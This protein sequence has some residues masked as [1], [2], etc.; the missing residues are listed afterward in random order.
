MNLLLFIGLLVVA[1]IVL[2]VMGVRGLLREVPQEERTYQDPLPGPMRAIWPLVSLASIGIRPF[3]HSANLEKAHRKLQ[4]AG[5]DFLISPEEL[6]GLRGVGAI[7]VTGFFLAC[8]YMLGFV[9]IYTLTVCLLLGIPLGWFYPSLWLSERRKLRVKRI[10]RDL[11]TFLDFMTMGVEAGLNVNG[12]IERAIA[13]TPAGPLTQEFA[14]MLRDLRAGLPRAQALERLA[15]R[16]DISQVSNFTSAVNQA[17]RVGASLGSVLRAQA[18]QRREE[19]FLRAEKLAMEAPVKMLFPLMVFFFPLVFL[20][21]AL[22]I[23]FRLQEE[24]YITLPLT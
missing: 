17:E 21:V 15:D 13:K 10:I 14:R 24:G 3:M 12:A 2:I 20:V 23:I 7:G 6:I 19:R 16:V 5:Q 4:A 8:T 11:P 22:F 9:S 1:A 18:M